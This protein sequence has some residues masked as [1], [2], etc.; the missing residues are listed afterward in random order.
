MP[1]GLPKFVEITNIGLATVDLTQYS[2]G[3]YTGANTMLS[4]NSILL[5]GTLAPGESYVAG[6]ENGD[7]AGVGTFFDLYQEDPDDFQFS[8]QF[9]GDDTI[10]LFFGQE[11]VVGVG[12]PVIDIYGVV[13]TD[14]TGEAWEYTDGFAE[15]LNTVTAPNPVFTPGEWTFGGVNSLE[16]GD[17]CEEADLI[18]ASTCP[19]TYDAVCPIVGDNSTWCP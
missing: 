5:Q 19:G 9:N 8:A 11:T 17:D 7:S 18:L 3:V 2:L 13:G 4:A 1:G 12:A 6:Y 10:V 14:G 15:R 16:T